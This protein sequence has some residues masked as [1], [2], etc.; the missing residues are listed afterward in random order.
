MKI[1][2]IYSTV[3]GNTEMVVEALEENLKGEDHEVQLERGESVHL[4]DIRSYDACV[5]ASPTYAKGMLHHHMARFAKG[6][7]EIHL[8]DMPF[9]AVAL[10][11]IAWGEEHHIAAAGHLEKL[12][13][14]VEG[15]RVLDTLKIDGDPELALEKEVADW[16]K[17][18]DQVLK[19]R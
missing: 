9:A 10:G 19:T 14:A 7:S 12:I 11:D 16:A 13:E 15:K 6:F 5:L 8:K 18:L 3:G 17:Q 4:D 1:L 2:I